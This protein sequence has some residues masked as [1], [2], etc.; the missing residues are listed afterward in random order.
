MDAGV[1]LEFFPEAG[2]YCDRLWVKL[3]CRVER[4]EPADTNV[5]IHKGLRRENSM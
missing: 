4:N 3:L 2:H 5:L 1:L